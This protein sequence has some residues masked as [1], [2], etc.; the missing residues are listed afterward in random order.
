MAAA[1]R[2]A[3]AA[4]LLTVAT[5]HV[6]FDVKNPGL[7][8]PFQVVGSLSFNTTTT[9]G[10]LACEGRFDCAP[11]TSAGEV[12]FSAVVTVT[13]VFELP[14]EAEFSE[15]EINAFAATTCAFAAWPYI[16]ETIQSL[17]LKAGIVPLVLEVLRLP[18]EI[19]VDDEPD[20]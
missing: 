16:R 1:A 9:E 20:A 2:M 14:Q 17:T 15:G 8:A 13:S 19:D 12:L 10:V 7:E 3:A 6:E 11:Q 4:K 5:T 18:L